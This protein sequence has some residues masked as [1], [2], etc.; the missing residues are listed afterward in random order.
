MYNTL[1]TNISENLSTIACGEKNKTKVFQINFSA[2][3]SHC[4][5]Q[6]FSIPAQPSVLQTTYSLGIHNLSSLMP[7]FLTLLPT[8]QQ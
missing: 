7:N 1:K 5:I 6:N 3:K 4:F 2:D 8:V